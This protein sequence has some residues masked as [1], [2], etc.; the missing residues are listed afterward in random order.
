MKMASDVA[1]RTRRA[2]LTHVAAGMVAVATVQIFIPPAMAMER[3]F[4]IEAKPLR[5]ALE[6]YAAA[7]GRQLLY[8]SELVA[9]LKAPSLLGRLSEDAALGRLLAKTNLR[10]RSTGP[11]TW[12]IERGSNAPANDSRNRG[13][14]PAASIR[15]PKAVPPMQAEA[16]DAAGI[17][18]TGTNIRGVGNG[19]SPVTV[20]NRTDIDRSGRGT[21]A[22]VLSTLPQNFGGSGTEDTSLAS[23]DRTV[24]NTGLGSSVNLRGLGSDATLTLVNGRRVAGSGGKGDFTDL[25]AIPTGAV[26]RIE[27]MSDGASALYGSDAVGGVVNVILRK[28]F[29]GSETRARIGSVTSGSTQDY[30]LSELLGRSWTGGHALLAY[31]FQHRQALPSVE[32]RFAASADLRRLGGDDF[33]S[34]YSDPGTILA[35]DPS[36]GAF[37]PKYAIPSGQNGVGL[38]LAD[39]KPGANLADTRP[40]SDLLP[41]QRRHGIY[42]TVEQELSP[43]VSLYAEGRYSNRRFKFNAASPPTLLVVTAGNPGYIDIDGSGAS[44]IGYSFARELGP[45]R[46]RGDVEAL[47]ATGGA[48]YSPGR[49]WQIDAYGSY[50]QEITHNRN[51]GLINGDALNEALGTIPDDPATPYSPG[52]DGFF[53][54]YGDMANSRAVL[55]FVGRGYQSERDRSRLLVGS[56]KADGTLM[57]LPAGPLKLAL[58][59]LARREFLEVGGESYYFGLA[60]SPSTPSSSRRTIV[61]A[62]GELAVP[63]FGPGNAVP[64]LSRLDLSL[65]LRHEHYSDFG[66]T[67][68]PKLGVVWEPLKGLR[69]RASWGTSFRAPALTDVSDPLVIVATQLPNQT[70]GFSPVLY[71]GGGNPGLKPERAKSLSAG[72]VV[73]P[74]ALPGLRMEATYFRTKF[75]QRIGTPVREQILKTLVDPSFSPFVR[76]VSPATNATDRA[77]V[78]A[79]IEDPASFV[80][81]NLPPE[82]FQ[83]IVDARQV[84]TSMIDVRGIDATL[85]QSFDWRDSAFALSLNGS[86]LLRYDTRLTPT[87]PISERVDRLGFPND[88]R[89][90]GTIDSSRGDFG[91]TVGVNY[92]SGQTDDVSIPSRPIASWTTLDLQLRYQPRTSKGPLAGLIVSLSAQNLLDADPPFV[93][94][95]SGIAYDASTADPLGRFVA[96]QVTKRF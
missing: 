78:V 28:D 47:S 15:R 83:A 77:D 70:G 23:S 71:L 95:S 91:S 75:D 5:A 21:I 4:A 62:F 35:F 48:V 92:L 84:N 19:A 76:L 18:V 57:R 44:Y 68:N 43:S 17:I 56:V 29:N 51:E 14:R 94:Q 64:G 61:A 69:V 50:A 25:S 90:R 38:K 36:T 13:P 53:N 33:R 7:T 54:P 11:N 16:P 59:G 34:F 10:A 8:S 93:N 12:I 81:R 2:L 37:V 20:I 89:V 82:F 27:V 45:I 49:D 30:Q 73:S 42:G 86:Y 74:A 88:L 85:S 66:S 32:R 3:V 1:G 40:G 60:P 58:G 52:R 80:P 67:T 31:E 41:D 72:V 55:D 65:A 6:E 63:V 22:E 46:T 9:G 26:E 87:A 96:L 24:L 79:L 39:L